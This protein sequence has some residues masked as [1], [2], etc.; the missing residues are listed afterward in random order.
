M[1][2]EFRI[3]PRDQY[4]EWN[5]FVD[6]SPQGSVFA[7]T[8]YLDAIG[9]PYKIG[10]V[11]KGGVIQGG[12]V[13]AKNEIRV[14][15]NPLFAKYLGVLL[16]PI[17][18]KYVNRL[19]TEKKIIENVA[20]EIRWCKSFDYTFHPHF[21]NWLPFY[22]NG[23][24]QETRYTYRIHSLKNMDQILENMD[25][26]ARNE[27]RKAQRNEVKIEDNI[28]LEDFYHINSLTYERQGGK[29]PYS[30]AFF[31][32][33]YNR[34]RE[35]NA[36]KLLGAADQ[37]S[38]LYAVCGIVYDKECSYFILNGINHSM[39]KVGA[40]SLLVM[41][42]IEFA[43]EVSNVFDFEGSMIKPI[44]SFYRGFG[45]ILTPYHNIWRNNLLNSTKRFAIRSYK[46]FRYGR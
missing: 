26:I 4:G 32:R 11:F 25:S 45:G 9:L 36:I 43:S 8:F 38:R 34:L 14:Y 33:F 18:G 17:E 7:K 39:P 1:S 3:L 44:E 37:G 27:I 19:T 5:G 21:R 42:A 29:I 13:L 30:F 6:I 40:N 20:L 28:P 35:H 15:S 24:A 23:H 10:A 46:K 31:E 22:W 41:K 2:M 12:I 16:R